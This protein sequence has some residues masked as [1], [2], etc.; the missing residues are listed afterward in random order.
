MFN[1][2]E[3]IE[4]L[5]QLDVDLNAKDFLSRTPILLALSRSCWKSA[6]L[7][8]RLGADLYVKVSLSLFIILKS[9]FQKYFYLLAFKYRLF[10][11]IN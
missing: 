5:V 10:Y 9:V 7:L 2:H 3:T 4:F 11:K 1:H 8:A 6:L